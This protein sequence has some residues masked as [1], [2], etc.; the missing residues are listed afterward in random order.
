MKPDRLEKIM[1]AGKTRYVVL[2]GVIGWGWLTA[3]LVSGWSFYA[4]E[5]MSTSQVVIIFFHCC[6]ESM[7]FRITS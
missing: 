7:C 2:Q 4:K 6:P 3:T 1:A 5:S